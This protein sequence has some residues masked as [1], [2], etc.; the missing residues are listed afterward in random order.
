M[1][2][3]LTLMEDIT[4][5]LIY[6]AASGKGY[7]PKNVSAVTFEGRAWHTML[8]IRNASKLAPSYQKKILDALVRTIDYS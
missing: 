7:T 5:R 3:E 2:T 6:S 4:Y 1:M 8:M